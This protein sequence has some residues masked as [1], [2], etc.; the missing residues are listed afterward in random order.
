[1]TVAGV[2]Y[3]T[4]ASLFGMSNNTA[5]GKYLRIGLI[6]SGIVQSERFI[7]DIDNLES[8]FGISQNTEKH[9]LEFDQNG[10]R[11]FSQTAFLG[12]NFGSPG[13][14]FTASSNKPEPVSD[15]IIVVTEP[16]TVI[17]TPNTSLQFVDV[18]PTISTEPQAKVLMDEVKNTIPLV[19]PQTNLRVQNTSILQPTP[20]STVVDTAITAQGHEITTTPEVNLATILYTENI[21]INPVVNTTDVILTTSPQQNLDFVS[22]TNTP[23]LL[24]QPATT[25]WYR[26]MVLQ[27]SILLCAGLITFLSSNSLTRRRQIDTTILV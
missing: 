2:Q 4:E 12:S 21:S 22:I 14:L 24:S 8:Q 15:S 1:L 26:G 7:S 5:G 27:L 9:T 23:M 16:Q 20:Q 6:H 25:H 3:Y 19:E 18:Q 10:N 17:Q 11:Q 13:Y